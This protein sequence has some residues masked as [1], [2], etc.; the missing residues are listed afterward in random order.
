MKFKYRKTVKKSDVV[1]PFPNKKYDIIYADPPW[2]YRDKAVAG[3]RGASFKYPTMKLEQIC[4]LPI[5]DIRSD[6]CALFMWATMPL[7]PVAFDVIDAWGFKYKTVA[8]TW[9]KHYKK[10]KTHFVGMGHW[11]R[12]NA[13]LCLLATRGRVKRVSDSVRQVVEAPIGKHSQK[14][15]AVRDR[16]VDLLGDLP[17]IELFAC[18]RVVGWD[19]WGNEC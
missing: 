12:A 9:V 5:K 1:L 8:F 4:E 6:N 17:K 16:I 3:K 2:N 10:A 18:K 19:A 13:E 15:D 14:P 7:L 11:T